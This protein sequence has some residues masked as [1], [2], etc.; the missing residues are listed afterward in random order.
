MTVN[1]NLATLMRVIEENMDKINEGEYL[2]AMNALGAL[3]QEVSIPVE[4]PPSY[5]D[6]F[7]SNTININE[8]ITLLGVNGYRAWFRVINNIPEYE[9]FQAE[10][11]LQLSVE[12]QN[13]LNRLS[14]QIM[15]ESYQEIISNPN[16]EIC[17]FI[18]R[19]SIGH[20]NY[21][22]DSATW[23]CVCGY[24]GK[25]KHWKK[26]EESE[27]HKEWSEHRL[28]PKRIIREMDRQI[29]QYENG[30]LIYYNYPLSGGVRYFPI[31]QEK[32]EWTHPELYANTDWKDINT[33]CKDINTDW[34]IY[35]RKM[36]K[37]TQ[38][39]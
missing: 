6:S 2:D 7:H 32:N 36:T 12:E 1:N 10:S 21:G 4:A 13:R 25:S 28:V 35:S 3:H 20:W 17:P 26:H 11:W 24:S 29:Q 5:T 22:T 31:R 15:A 39:M 27:R 9:N 14:T 34:T 37:P 38:D 23:K 33:D 30:I 8:A 19:H 16:P 18:A